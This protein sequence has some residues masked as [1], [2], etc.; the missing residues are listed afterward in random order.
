MGDVARNRRAR[1]I[2]LAIKPQNHRGFE[3]GSMNALATSGAASEFALNAAKLFLNSLRVHCAP[4][5]S[6]PCDG[7]SKTDFSGPP[8]E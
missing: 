4:P 6:L 7:V 1:G 3:D 5:S 8:V 2:L